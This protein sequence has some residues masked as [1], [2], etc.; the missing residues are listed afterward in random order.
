MNSEKLD[1]D[2]EIIREHCIEIRCNYNTYTNLFCDENRTVLS[3]AAPTF[4]TDVAAIMH[5]D[6]VLQVCKLMDPASTRRRGQVLENLTL[7]L[8]NEQLVEKGL[9]T[10]EIKSVSDRILIYGDKLTPARNKRIAH[11]D[12]EHQINAVVLGE[13]PESVLFA[14]LDD[15]QRYCDLVGIAVGFGPLDFTSSSCPGDALD[16]IKILKCGVNA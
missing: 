6:W 3:K 8:I 1:K 13:T 11:C 16:L 12:R 9:M 7:K 14:F 5:R 2:F 10:P 4:F 15:I